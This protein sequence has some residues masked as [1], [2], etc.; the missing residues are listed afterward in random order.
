MSHLLS[1]LVS[2]LP[3][4][5]QAIYGHPDIAQDTSRACIDRLEK[6]AEIHDALCTRLGRPLRVLD[7]GCAQGYFSLS[8]ASRG[9]EVHGVD[10]LDKNILVCQA[11]AQENPDVKVTFAVGRLEETV[12]ALKPE[13]YDLVLGLSVLHHVVH[14]HGIA[15]VQR[16]LAHLADVSKVV[17]LE[18]ALR[19]EPL[20]WG[21]SQPVHYLELL[22]DY[23]FIHE[24]GFFGTHLS[25]VERP[26]LVASNGYWV[27]AQEALPLEHWSTEAHS[28]A[29]GTHQGSRRYYWFEDRFAKI[30]RFD[31]ERGVFN[32]SEFEQELKFLSD[33]PNGFIG[34]R[35]FASSQENNEGM[36]VMERL[37]GRLLLDVLQEGGAFDTVGVLTEI[38]EQLVALEAAGLYHQDIRTWNVMVLDSGEL[39]LIDYGSIGPVAKDCVWPDNI[40]LAFMIFVHELSAGRVDDPSSLRAVSFSPYDLSEPLRSWAAGLWR[41]PI[42]DW[43]F[44]VLL[45]SLRQGP[46]D[47]SASEI[48]YPADLWGQALEHAV[49]AQKLHVAYLEQK[50]TTERGYQ[51]QSDH[52]IFLLE[53][54]SAQVRNELVQLHAQFNAHSHQFDE[55]SRQFNEHVHILTDRLHQSDLRVQQKENELALLYLSSSWR[56]TSPLRW[57]TRKVIQWRRK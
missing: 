51:L 15:Q 37:R 13:Q 46:V 29:K 28:L 6:I 23:A 3:E 54:W 41:K 40:F 57:I 36:L 2:D 16:W 47:V 49:Q 39:R 45:D 19:E 56:L 11:L 27:S 52:K 17:I 42:S 34:P 1:Q 9:A 25:V 33:I 55:V 21:P 30:I 50:I 18:L 32:R 12:A 5:Y 8:L 44:K 20:Y 4:I 53:N 43:S 24:L 22:K 10:F 35:L 38:L 31:G 26:L 14:E 7:M 48:V